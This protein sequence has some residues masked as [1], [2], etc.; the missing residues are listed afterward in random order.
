MCDRILVVQLLCLHK[1][2]W[3]T[4]NLMNKQSQ[5]RN[6]TSLVTNL[7]RD[8]ILIRRSTKTHA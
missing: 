1:F 7:T 6:N 8:L 2:F 5:R 3:Q 4:T